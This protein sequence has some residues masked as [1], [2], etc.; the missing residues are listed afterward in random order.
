MTVREMMS[1]P[2]AKGLTMA[3]LAT[4]S[5]ILLIASTGYTGE[6]HFRI[7][8]AVFAFGSR[9]AINDLWTF[10]QYLPF[11]SLRFVFAYEFMRYY[12]GT[13]SGLRVFM[14]GLVGEIPPILG[15]LPILLASYAFQFVGT[16]PLHLIIGFGYVF[17]YPLVEDT[18]IWPQE[19]S[20]PNGTE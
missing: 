16:I 7:V 1:S 13:T 15:A 18:T 19:G 2:L 4:L 8:S 10:F 9:F 3:I 14:A 20:P 6:F 5:P 12:T 17:L 11:V